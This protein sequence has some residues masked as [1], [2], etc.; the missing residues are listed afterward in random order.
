[1]NTWR[2][3]AWRLEEVIANTGAPLRGEQVPTL[4]EHD[5]VDQAPV[6]PPPLMDEDI[7]A[8]LIRLDQAATIQAQAMIAQ[9]NREVVPRPHQQVTT[10]AP[11]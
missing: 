7:R 3:V 4:E 5:N 2:N 11:V 1:M 10:M 6:N 9:A 8:P